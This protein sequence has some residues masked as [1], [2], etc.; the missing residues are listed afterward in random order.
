MTVVVKVTMVVIVMIVVIEM[1]V[2]I[3]A[4]VVTIVVVVTM[5][6]V[7]KMWNLN[8]LRGFFYRNI[9]TS[10]ASKVQ[11]S[12]HH[13]NFGLLTRSEYY[14]YVLINI[15]GSNFFLSCQNSEQL[16]LIINISCCHNYLFGMNFI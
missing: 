9:L 1:I 14:L 5:V 13:S 10:T 7:T 12:P 3:M 2:V 16:K 15:L 8:H 11:L 4:T 6:V